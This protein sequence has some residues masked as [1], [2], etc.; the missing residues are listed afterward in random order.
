M[1]NNNNK[2]L[3]FLDPPYLQLC[4]DFY[5]DSSINIY[6]YLMKHN[7]NGMLSYIVLVLEDIWIIKLLFRNHIFIT[8]DKKYQTSKKQ[9]KHLII[10]NRDSTKMSE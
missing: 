10:N 3:I 2:A 8:Y 4:N 1:Y 5:L 7:I 9:T 6:E